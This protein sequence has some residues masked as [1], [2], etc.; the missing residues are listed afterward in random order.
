MTCGARSLRDRTR[1]MGSSACSRTRARTPGRACFGTSSRRNDGWPR[2]ARG[3]I[4]AGGPRV[5]GPE[6][7]HAELELRD[8]VVRLVAD[9]FAV[10]LA[11][12]AGKGEPQLVHRVEQACI[13]GEDVGHRADE[14]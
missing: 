3:Q 2:R 12:L 6:L 1:A 7:L 11:R 4:D 13:A 8:V 10:D 5:E 9:P 14:V